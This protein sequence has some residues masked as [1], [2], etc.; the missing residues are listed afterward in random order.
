M[1]SVISIKKDLKR[2]K[3]SIYIINFLLT[4][5]APAPPPDVFFFPCGPFQPVSLL[6]RGLVCDLF[7]LSAHS[8]PVTHPENT[9][10]YGN[11][12]SSRWRVSRKGEDLEDRSLNQSGPKDMCQNCCML[13]SSEDVKGETEGL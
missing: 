5:K 6:S 3:R 4:R 1:E 2:K 7:I 13:R 8:V 11:T 10:D 9:Q 12:A